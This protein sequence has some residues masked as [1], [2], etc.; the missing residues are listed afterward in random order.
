MEPLGTLRLFQRS[1][2]HNIRYK[3]MVSDG[4]SKTHSLLVREGVYSSDLDDQVEKLDCVGHVQKRLGTALRNL[5]MK[6]RGDKLSDGKSI[7]GQ[8]RLT[9]SLINSLQN[10]YR[11][12]IRSNKG[13]LDNMIRAVQAT[14]LHSN[15]S[16][17]APRH[18]LCP[19]GHNSWCKWQVA[20][21]LG[22]EYHHTK[23]PIPGAI[24]HLLK[25]IYGRLGSR[26]LLEKCLEGYTQNAN[27]SLHSTIF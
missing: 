11:I 10:Y 6:H 18:H 22:E 26:D 23:P 14:L 17:E 8:G 9:D 15:S 2:D 16:D 20:K 7:G 4:D 27:E 24:V 5:K 13:N 1:L 19:P 21:T 25:P 12:A 3:Y